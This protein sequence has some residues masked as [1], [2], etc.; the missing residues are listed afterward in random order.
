MTARRTKFYL[1]KQNAKLSGVCSG[2]ADYTG[3]DPFLVRMSFLAMTL[4]TFPTM[5]FVYWLIAWM[6]PVKP[7]GLY[8]DKDEEQFW[9]GFRQSPARSTG[10]VRAKFR[11]VDRRLAEVELYYTS[12]NNRLANEIDSL[13]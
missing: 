6:A 7:I 10:D 13:K 12:R 3:F 8:D 5:V 2:I 9:R 1:D 4:L 11:D